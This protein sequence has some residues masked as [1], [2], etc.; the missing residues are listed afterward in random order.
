MSRR[1]RELIVV[2]GFHDVSAVRQAVDAE[3]VITNG[4]ALS[5]E[6]LGRIRRAR[7]VHGVI[8]LT[9]PDTAGE[10]IRRRII[11]AVGPCKHAHI[12][13]DSATKA[14]DIGVENARPAAIL[15]ALEAARATTIESRHEFSV[16]DL[17]RHGLQ[18][19]PGSRARRDA[20]GADLNLGYAN[21]RQLLS[22]LNHY[23]VT[24]AEFEASAGRLDSYESTGPCE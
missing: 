23:G 19:A 4:F 15:A 11:D 6:T 7:D 18:G 2:E 24:R 1:I 3:L 5:E 9:D 17:I 10:Q 20:L 12:P 8:I 16:A 14:G 22:R 13:R 21:S